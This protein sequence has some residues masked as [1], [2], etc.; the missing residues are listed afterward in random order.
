[1]KEIRLVT[2]SSQI[3]LDFEE[4]F[5]WWKRGKEY[6]NELEEMEWDVDE[7]VCIR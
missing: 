4:E 5:D 6:M 1:M 7:D 2:I 3:S